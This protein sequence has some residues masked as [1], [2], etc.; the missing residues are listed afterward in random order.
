MGTWGARVYE[1]D[2]ALDV[3]GEFLER[4]A[5]YSAPRAEDIS[6]IEK[7]VYSYFAEDDDGRDI[8]TL[9]LCCIELETGTLTASIKD[10]TLK[11]ITDNRDISRWQDAGSEDIKKRKH[12]LTLI[13]KYIEKYDG[14]PVKRKSWVELQ[15]DDA[16]VGK[17]PTK[18]ASSVLGNKLDD[19]SWH[20]VNDPPKGVSDDKFE[21][22][23]AAHIA[24]FLYW[25]YTRGYHVISDEWPAVDAAS[26][27]SGKQSPI[28]LLLEG[29]G[30]L[31]SGEAVE[32]ALP[33]TEAYYPGGRSSYMN[34]FY[35]LLGDGND[36]YSFEPNTE[37][38]EKVAKQIDVRLTEYKKKPYVSSL[39]LRNR[40]IVKSV[41]LIAA[42]IVL[43]AVSI[44]IRYKNIL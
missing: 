8:V 25:L 38:Y 28:D 42:G 31:F 14:T 16:N 40:L 1:D 33:F 9:A 23:A 21:R 13:R 5:T 32:E 34:D 12:E 44:Y 6:H 22:Y 20:M 18:D 4:Y 17:S 19:V 26:L 35:S 43:I 7:E 3:R 2:T 15:K 39:S 29:D 27:R 24:A 36:P 41:G 10:R 11:V 37:Q 30:K